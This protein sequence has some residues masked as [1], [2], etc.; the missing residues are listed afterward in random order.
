[1]IMTA[2]YRKI[3][4]PL[5]GSQLA[6][7]VL[8]QLQR[9]AAPAATTLVLINVVDLVRYA[10]TT[11]HHAPPEFFTQLRTN[12]ETYLTEQ[13][14]QLQALG[15]QVKGH[16][17]EG[18]PTTAILQV[19]A[20]EEVD[21]IAMTTHGRSGFVRWALGSVAERVVRATPLPIFLVRATTAWSDQPLRR[22]LVPLDGSLLAEEALPEAVALAKNTGAEVLLLQV[23]QSLDKGSRQILFKNETDAEATL[24]EWQVTAEAYLAQ[25]AQPLPAEGVASRYQALLGDVAATIIDTTEREGI[26]LL[27][28]STHGRS[29]LGRWVYGSVANKVLRGVSCPLLLIHH[30]QTQ[31]ALA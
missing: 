13:R 12:A 20:T 22:I 23:I 21:L 17:V 31:G 8:P 5:D 27:V 28:M 29:G 16:V 14:Q 4:V 18:D 6:E 11:A 1:M 9:L 24:S 25:V 26:D 30:P 10:I 2:L 7:Q 19:A 15:F 3:L